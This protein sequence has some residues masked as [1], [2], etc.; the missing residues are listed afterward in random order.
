MPFRA[1]FLVLQRPVYKFTFSLPFGTVIE[2]DSEG[3]RESSRRGGTE[4]PAL[5]GGPPCLTAATERRRVTGVY[6]APVGG[7]RHKHNGKSQGHPPL[8]SLHHGHLPRSCFSL[9]F[10]FRPCER[11][12]SCIITLWKYG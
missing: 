6:D 10:F 9:L 12:L 7:T 3:G 1:I 4:P 5:V 2:D 11:E 8:S